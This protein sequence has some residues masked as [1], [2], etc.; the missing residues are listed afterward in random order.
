MGRILPD[1]NNFFVVIEHLPQELR[2]RFTE[3]REMDLSVQSKLKTF[4]QNNL[5]RANWSALDRM[6]ELDT[7]VKLFFSDCKRYPGELPSSIDSEF[8]NLRKEYYKVLED[9]DEKVPNKKNTP[10]FCAWVIPNMF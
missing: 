2:D 1:V 9:T 8:Q 7:R 10:A 5:L 4:A 3:M 6:D